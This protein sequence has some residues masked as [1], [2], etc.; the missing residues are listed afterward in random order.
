MFNARMF[1]FV[2]GLLAYLVPKLTARGYVFVG[3]EL[4][5]VGFGCLSRVEQ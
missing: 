1:S 3:L 2:P 4:G 5:W